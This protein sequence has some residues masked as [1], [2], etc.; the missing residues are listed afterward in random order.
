MAELSG[1]GHL[2]GGRMIVGRI[3][4]SQHTS[5]QFRGSG[6]LPSPAEPDTVMGVA[7][8]ENTIVI[9]ESEP[10]AGKIRL[11][12]AFVN[13]KEVWSGPG[14]DRVDALLDA[15]QAATGDDDGVP[16]N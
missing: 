9:R 5:G 16:N 8:V 14:D 2:T 13:G 11:Y 12:D 3:Y 7:G 15:I 6:L 4:S 1:E 10:I